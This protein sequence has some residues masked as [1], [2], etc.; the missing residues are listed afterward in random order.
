MTVD[1]ASS[2]AKE[3]EGPHVAFAALLVAGRHGLPRRRLRRK[4][5]SALPLA[6]L[7]PRSCGR[8]AAT[9]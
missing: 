2:M 9:F 7:A 5:L 1:A 6:A 3:V 8:R 4:L